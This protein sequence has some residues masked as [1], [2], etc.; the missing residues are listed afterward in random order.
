FKI[1]Q[2]H[3]TTSAIIPQLSRSEATAI[4]QQVELRPG[5]SITFT[6]AQVSS[7]GVLTP[8]ASY[9]YGIPPPNAKDFGF[10]PV[11]SAAVEWAT[12][13]GAGRD[14]YAFARFRYNR[15]TGGPGAGLEEHYARTGRGYAALGETLDGY[16]SRFDLVAFQRLNDTLT[17][18]LTGSTLAG[19]KALRYAISRSGRLGYT[20]LAF[21][22]FNG[23]R[24][25][26]LYMTDNQH[27]IGRVGQLREQI[28][29]G[30][31]VHPSDYSGAQDVRVTPGL[32]FDT[33][34]VRLGPSTISSSA[35]LGE[36]VYNYGRATLSSDISFWSTFPA[37]P[38]LQ[39]NGG[40]TFAH[41]APPFASTYRT[42][43]VGS[44]W[45]ASS[46]FNLVSSLTFTNDFG[47]SLGFGRP[48]FSAAF[49]VRF[50]RKNGM[51]IEIGSIVPFGLGNLHNAQVFNF[52]IFK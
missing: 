30:H 31:D 36:T 42:Y 11:P 44:T 21:S 18:T 10:S 22:Q 34:T 35:D 38:H 25:D 24:S 40:A 15:Y 5:A 20:S 46:A 19:S 51:G 47:Q 29:F 26:D 4:A 9:T 49:D 1:L 3:F 50:R 12:M 45:K 14:A 32:H 33:A 23:A 37:S 7:G 52:R 6:N 16:G 28:D 17:Q 43:T 41:N 39:F 2:G 27:P 8:T 13:L 48:Q